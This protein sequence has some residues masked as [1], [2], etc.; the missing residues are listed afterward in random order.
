M[1]SKS[2]QVYSYIS[3]EGYEVEFLVPKQSV[4]NTSADN[5]TT[6]HLEVES[7]NIEGLRNYIG[8]FEWKVLYDGTEI[9]SAYNKINSLTGNLEGGTMISTAHL[10]PIV[11]DEVIITYGFYDAGQG[12][13]GLTNRDQCYVTIC[14]T[15]NRYWMGTIAPP[16]SA[17]AQKPF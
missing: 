8:R 4:R 9:A 6:K 11:T 5:F 2:I 3:V 10:T 13:A 15:A 16:G 7:S 14:S 1:P 17:E 12:E